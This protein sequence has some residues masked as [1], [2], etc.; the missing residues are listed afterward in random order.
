MFIRFSSGERA[1]KKEENDQETEEFSHHPVRGIAHSHISTPRT[2][3]SSLPSQF[4]DKRVIKLFDHL[5]ALS[6]QRKP[7]NC[8]ELMRLLAAGPAIFAGNLLHM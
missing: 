6:P 3:S 2:S 1:Q 5:F 8:P 4:F 7:I